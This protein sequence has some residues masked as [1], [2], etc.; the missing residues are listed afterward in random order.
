MRAAGVVTVAMVSVLAA[1]LSPAPSTA[2]PPRHVPETTATPVSSSVAGIA[3]SRRGRP[4]EA[5][6]RSIR[7]RRWRPAIG[8]PNDRGTLRVF[9]IQYKQAVAN[10]RS[11]R[12][13][14]TAMR[15]MMEDF[16]VP[17]LDPH[18]PS[19]VVFPEDVGL[20]TLAIGD[21]GAAVREQAGSPLRAPAGDRAPLSAASALA[22]LNAAYTPQVA[23]YQQR[24]G[25]IDPRKQ[26]LVAATDTFARAFSRTFS[27]IAR[28]YG[29]YVVASN[30]QARYRAT[31]DPLEVAAFGDPAARRTGVAYVATSPRVT[32]GT[33]LWAPY[34]TRPKSPAG[35]RNLLFRN[36]K[37]PLTSLETDL[38]GLD[39]GASTGRAGRRNARGVVVEGFRLGFATSLPAFTYGYRFGRRPRTL[40]PCADT[41]LTYMACM[42]RLGVEVVVQAE[43]NPARWAGP[44]GYST[45]QPLEWMGSTWRA[46]A[47]PTVR[48]DYNV[49]AHMVGNLLDLAF[50][51]QSAITGRGAR[52][53]RRHYVGNA[54]FLPEDERVY[55][56]YAGPKRG[57]LALAP[58]VVPD[59]RRS[60]LRDV[61]A[62]L[63]PGSGEPR[64]NQYLETALFADLV[65]A[66]RR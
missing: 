59:G 63:A 57:F 48:F 54:R 31:R 2:S 30:N 42:D 66:W 52:A 11:Y 13:F 38:L 37:V 10:V 55:R 56:P 44:G 14:R 41:S 39:E 3:P 21:R 35:E 51:G 5:T 16:V 17:H 61:G 12:S 28:D 58:W 46:V 43:A 33:F 36:D 23:A 22:E 65:P 60:R 1:T 4:P 9:A 15:C 24:F 29:V 27:D 34:P 7:P 62:A 18:K 26:V 45:W 8:H 50:D 47:D 25:P 49:T 64:E 20:M 40:R 19:L 32:N 53:P 6:C